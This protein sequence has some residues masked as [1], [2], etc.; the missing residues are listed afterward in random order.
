V[1][2]SPSPPA[3]RPPTSRSMPPLIGILPMV[4]GMSR[5]RVPRAPP[6]GRASSPLAAALS[7]LSTTPIDRPLPDG[8]KSLR[9]RTHEP[10]QSPRVLLPLQPA[11]VPPPL[12]G[13]PPTEAGR[14]VDC[15]TARIPIVAVTPGAT[16]SKASLADVR[17]LPPPCTTGPSVLTPWVL[18]PSTRVRTPLR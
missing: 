6:F 13:P 2:R 18:P 16:A 15:A 7:T 11:P 4:T 17:C 12:L 10:P 9:T 3:P 1:H 8:K 5:S 14:D